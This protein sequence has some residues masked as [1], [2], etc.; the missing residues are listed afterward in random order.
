M[1]GKS[2]KRMPVNSGD[3]EGEEEDAPV[4]ADG[5]AVLADARNIARADGEQRADA[6][7]AEDEAEDAA[8]EGEQNA[9]GE[10]LADDARAA[11]SHGGANGEFTLAAGG[12]DEQKIGDVG[13]GDEED[14]ADGSEED[15]ERRAH[16]ADDGVAERL[17]AEVVFGVEHVGIARRNWSAASFHLGVGLGEGHAGL[18]ATSDEEVV[19]LVVAVGVDLEGKPEVGRRIGIEGF[20]DDADDGV[21][22]DC[23]ASEPCRRCADR[24]QICAATGRS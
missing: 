8:G 19:A 9:F 7:E 14:E 18:E 24:H 5:G 20:S 11:G 17:D 3:A 15:E 4:D 12:A 21:R 6:D 16:I 10:Q 22:L 23:R 1:A 2:P 13:A